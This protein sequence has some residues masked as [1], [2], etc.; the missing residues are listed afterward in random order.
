M[1][2]GVGAGELG[3]AQLDEVV[4]V[5]RLAALAE[6][7]GQGDDLTA[8]IA[9]INGQGAPG[10]GQ[11]LIEPVGVHEQVAE[12]GVHLQVARIKAE[13]TLHG[14]RGVIG[15]AQ[16]AVDQSQGDRAGAGGGEVVGAGGVAG[17]LGPG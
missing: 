14:A 5:S 1:A 2:A 16:I 17:G 8:G 4:E 6:L 3:L 11:R 7:H 9:G 10:A 15:A 13:G 12:V